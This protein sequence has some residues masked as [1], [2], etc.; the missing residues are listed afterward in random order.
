MP[1]PAVRRHSCKPRQRP[2]AAKVRGRRILLCLSVILCSPVIASVMM[3]A[4][5]ALTAAAGKATGIS[6]SMTLGQE[7]PGLEEAWDL[8][9]LDPLNKGKENNQGQDG[10]DG[11][12]DE[13]QISQD[14]GLDDAAVWEIFPDT[15]LEDDTPQGV[16]DTP[17]GGEASPAAGQGEGEN[18][19][20]A[21][22]PGPQPYPDS[23]ENHSGEIQAMT[24]PKQKG[25][26]FFSLDTA[27]QVRNNTEQPLQS[28][29]DE[30]T[31]KPEFTI[32]LNEE[33]QVLI[34][35]T[36]TTESYEPY[37]RNFYDASFSSRTTD[38]TKNMVSVGDRITA[39][40]EAAGIGVIHDKTLH[41]YPSYNGSYDRSAVTVK[42]QLQQYPSIKVVLDIHRDAIE[43][44]DGV[45]IAPTV[46]IDG[47]KAAQIMI[48]SGCDNGT[49]NMPNYWKNFR[50]ACL[51]QGKIEGMFP[52]LTRP[53]LFAYK[54]YNQDL[55]TGSLL[56][57]VGGHANSIE[58]A[59][60][61]GELI[62][63]GLAE[64]L[65]SLQ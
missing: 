4:L 8:Q 57:E 2:R 50:F 29:I 10:D 1:P 64:A 36:H 65:K 3:K 47:K 40:L 44:Q 52:G 54:K 53:V 23:L 6:A 58:E 30:S 45:R 48:I 27:G 39:E 16:L 5:P 28:L 51:L 43:R 63:K 21:D 59:Q 15:L 38:E 14:G 32:Q 42:S 13:T 9:G 37:T 7:V 62:G 33:P 17:G 20:N 55:T 41:D 22:G 26:T 31:K 56:I 24:Y 19:G 34:M 11:S 46:E 60:Y 61:S 18:S 35:H 25:D 12:L 49:M